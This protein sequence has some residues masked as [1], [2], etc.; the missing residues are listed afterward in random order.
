MYQVES[1]AMEG[2]H[3]FVAFETTDKGWMWIEPQS[4]DVYSPAKPGQHLCLATTPSDCWLGN[5]TAVG[6]V[7]KAMERMCLEGN[8]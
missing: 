7:D 2:T 3:T 1:N 8:L 5:L 6:A 4:D